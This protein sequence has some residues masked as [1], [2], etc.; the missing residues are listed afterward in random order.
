MENALVFSQSEARN[1]FMFIINDIIERCCQNLYPQAAKY[2]AE[3]NKHLMEVY[4]MHNPK[5]L[6]LYAVIIYR[7]CFQFMNAQNILLL[8]ENLIFCQ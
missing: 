2:C 5:T 6:F 3:A 8:E 1:F 4:E 7:K